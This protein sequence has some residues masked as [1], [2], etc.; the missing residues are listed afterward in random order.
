MECIK[1][2]ITRF[3]TQLHSSIFFKELSLIPGVVIG[4]EFPNSISPNETL[5][6]IPNQKKLALRDDQSSVQG[7]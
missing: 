2:E 4:F 1:K 5:P 7:I 6:E 3:L